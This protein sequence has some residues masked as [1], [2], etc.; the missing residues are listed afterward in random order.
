MSEQKNDQSS[1]TYNTIGPCHRDQI[2]DA[3]IRLLTRGFPRE[4][5]EVVEREEVEETDGDRKRRYR[6][7]DVIAFRRGGGD[8]PPAAPAPCHA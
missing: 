5:I 8:A 4:S 6:I 1:A 2:A 3:I 7:V